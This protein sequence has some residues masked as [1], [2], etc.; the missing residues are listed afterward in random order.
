[1]KTPKTTVVFTLL[2]GGG[3]LPAAL[4]QA[5]AGKGWATHIVTF[6]GQPQ[7][8]G[9]PKSVLSHTEFPIG[10]EGKILPHL[11]KLGTTHVALAG[12]LSKPSLLSLK[13]DMAGMKVIARAAQFHD[14]AL[15]RAVTEAL[16]AAGLIVVPVTELAPGLLAPEGI[17]S[18]AKPTTDDEADIALAHSALKLLGKLDIG[19]AAIVHR[20]TIL[21]VEGVEGTDALIS[22]CATLRGE[23]KG[24]AGWL[25]KIAKPGQTKLADLPTV[26]PQT[27]AALARHGYRGLAIQAKTTL[28][29]DQSS[30][31]GELNKNKMIFISSKLK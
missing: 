10:K 31:I 6:Q 16:T 7:P 2:A 18:K 3:N 8:V 28:L 20:G 27:V 9:L 13:P 24:P 4:A 25:V 11:K 14:D 17:L 22:R 1:M 26:G 12:H 15:L 29:L 19:Q 21:G 5:A 23:V 30:V